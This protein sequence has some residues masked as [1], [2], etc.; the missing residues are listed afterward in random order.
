MRKIK[1]N[2]KLHTYR[3]F[4][5]TYGCNANVRDSEHIAGVLEQMGILAAKDIT[6]ANLIILNTC[7]VRQNAENKVFGEVGFLKK[8]KDNE[9]DLLLGLCGCMVYENAV[10]DKIQKRIPF[11]DFV[12]SPNAIDSIPKI[13]ATLTK[14]KKQLI[15]IKPLDIVPNE[16]LSDVRH[17]RVK[18]LV[19][20]MYGCDKFCSYCVV[21]F[22]RGRI[23]SRNQK[24]IL[25]E[26]KL[27][28]KQNYKE[29]ILLGQNVN[30]Y[31]IDFKD[32][33]YHFSDL[34]ADVAKTNI[35][36][37][38]FSTSNPWNFD[39]KIVDVMKQFPNIMPYVHLPI[40]SGDQ[41]VLRRMNR[42]MPIAKYIKTINYLK[43]NI[44][45]CAISTDI[46]V[47]FPNET[48]KQFDHTL[49]LYK[50]IQFD[51]AY[52][53]IYSPRSGTKSALINDKIALQTKSQR[54]SV[55]NDLVRH[56]A[57]LNNLKW[58]NKEVLVLVEGQSKTNPHILTGYSPQ[59]KVVN[60]NG[61]AK[62]GAIVKVK[63]TSASRFS[64]NGEL[65]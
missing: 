17:S 36:R 18:A 23:R 25:D 30:A 44:P 32:Q 47:G 42:F 64:L 21:P 59:W 65:V 3:Y 40:Q 60:F 34:L 45:D 11:V 6:Q 58:V 16:N 50:K 7:A 56:Y 51:N 1:E 26:I 52:T 62:V 13:L 5:R 38:R 2:S 4:I 24:A 28:I 20:I 39:L 19:N 43:T 61:Q 57:K 37:I 49:Q 27:L 12:F 33:H 9:P 14:Q 15:Q 55:L 22:T 35:P 41:T 10:I 63:I 54:L 48:S 53:F 46:I 31:G 29:V 8:R